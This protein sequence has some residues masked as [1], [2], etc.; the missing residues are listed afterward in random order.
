MARIRVTGWNA[1]PEHLLELTFDGATQA[2]WTDFRPD[3]PL[4]FHW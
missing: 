1:G 4:V 2:K 3:L